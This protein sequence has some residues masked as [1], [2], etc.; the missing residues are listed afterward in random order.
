MDKFLK[1]NIWKLYKKVNSN[2]IEAVK[3]N[4]LEIKC[5]ENYK[6]VLSKRGDYFIANHR[7]KF[8]QLKYEEARTKTPFRK[9]EW[10][11]KMAV[12]EKFYQLNNREKLEIFDYQIPL[13][14]ERTKDTKGLGKIDLLAKISNT[15]YLIE[16]KTIN[17]L[18][19]PL[20]AILEIYAYWQQLGG[21]N[22]NENFLKYLEKENCK[23]LKKAILL[24]KSKD[25][26]SIYQE[27]ISSKDMLSIMEELEIELFVATL[28]ESEEI[29]EDKRTKIKTIK[30]FE[31]S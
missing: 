11:C 2:D 12:L 22:L 7:D 9:E 3:K 21:E 23:K 10:I 24:F 1:E 18:E 26:K 19:I 8:N 20:K 17:S 4:L 14:N 31:I 6:N 27:L 13:K 16:V 30:R 5:E 28:D 25:K 29:E 15:A